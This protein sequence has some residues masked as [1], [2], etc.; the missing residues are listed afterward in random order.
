MVDLLNQIEDSINVD[1]LTTVI[2]SCGPTPMMK[3]VASWAQSRGIGCQ[4]SLEERMGCGYGTCVVCV[5]DTLEGRKKVCAD[6][7]VFTAE[8][9]GW[10]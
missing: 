4:L 3:A 1:G 10:A 9:L 8:E 2:L 7:P 5:V 6:G